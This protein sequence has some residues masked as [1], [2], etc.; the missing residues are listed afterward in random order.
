LT[1]AANVLPALCL[2]PRLAVFLERSPLELT[3]VVL[4]LTDPLRGRKLSPLMDSLTPLRRSGLRLTVNEAGSDAASMRQIRLLQPD[5][6]KLGRGLIAEIDTDSSCQDLVADLVEFGRQTGAVV[7]A[8]GFETAPELAMLG[9]L[10]V[11]AGQ[12]H[13]MGRPTSDITEW[14]RWAVPASTPERPRLPTAG[15]AQEGADRPRCRGI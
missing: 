7:S 4:E 14:A 2:D 9:R 3:N 10:G 12:G 5:V 6:I 15:Q 8:T 11:T 1:A 13:L